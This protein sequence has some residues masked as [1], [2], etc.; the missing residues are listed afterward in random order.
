MFKT[1]PSKHEEVTHLK[2]HI[3]N[4]KYSLSKSQNPSNFMIGGPRLT[5]SHLVQSVSLGLVLA[6]FSFIIIKLQI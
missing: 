3:F 5:N 1:G 4:I 2:I 6:S